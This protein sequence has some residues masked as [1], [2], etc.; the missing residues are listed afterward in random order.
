MMTT[1]SSFPLGR[2]ALAAAAV[3]VVV[4][5]ANAARAEENPRCAPRAAI[6]KQLADQFHE[7]ATAVGVAEHGTAAV[8]VLTSADGA[9][10]TLLYSM[11]TGI[12]CL[13]VAG[14]EWQSVPRVATSDPDSDPEP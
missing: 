5:G 3:L 8:E 6:L 14:E 4:L 13:V 10:W 12:S 1:R 7:R 2:G 9:T 11:P